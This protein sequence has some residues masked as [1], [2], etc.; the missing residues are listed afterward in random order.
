MAGADLSPD[1]L[2][3]YAMESKRR[4]GLGPHDSIA[5][6]KLRSLRNRTGGRR[7]H[8]VD[9]HAV[10]CSRIGRISDGP[11]MLVCRKADTG[12]SHPALFQIDVQ[13]SGI[14]GRRLKESS[15]P[16]ETGL[17]D[18]AGHAVMETAPQWQ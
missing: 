15:N 2:A 10:D 13:D 12:S 8:L 4:G 14:G 7:G 1:E 16:G 6:V 3:A 18:Q 9:R 5:V 11:L 17:A